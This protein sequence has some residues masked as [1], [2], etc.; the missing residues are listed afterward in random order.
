MLFGG[1]LIRGSSFRDFTDRFFRTS[2][3]LLFESLFNGVAIGSVLLIA[4][5]GLAIV[6]GLMGVSSGI[7]PSRCGDAVTKCMF[8]RES[9]A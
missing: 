1:V 9:E 2:V 4:A 3:Q 7:L 6:F 8:L 5:L